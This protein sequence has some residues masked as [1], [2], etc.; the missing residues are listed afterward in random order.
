MITMNMANLVYTI[1]KRFN[2]AELNL[3][4]R[5]SKGGQHDITLPEHSDLQFVKINNKSQ[6]VKQEDQTITL[7]L[8]PGSQNVSIEWHQQTKSLFMIHGPKLKIGNQAVNAKVTFKMP[9]DRWILGVKGPKLGPA[10]LFWSYLFIVIIAAIALGKTTITPLKT[11][12]WLL[13]GLGLT[14]VD[15]FIALLIVGWLLALGFRREHTPPDKWF[16]FNATQLLLAIWT[17]AAMIGLY[18]AIEKG[19]LGNPDMQIAGNH[20]TRYILNWTQDRISSYMPQPYVFSLHHKIYQLLMLS[21]ALWLAFSLLKW[22]RWGWESF[23]EGG[24]WRKL[25]RKKKKEKK[26]PDEHL[27][28]ST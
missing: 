21:W 26:L 18:Q 3:K 24:F 16:H 14:Q 10:V 12:Q 2:K 6:P 17:I 5:S 8:Q 9:Q 4:I 27:Q 19:L 15:P 23:S 13:L 11:F 7:P 25:K 1:G 22:L 28:E 20:S